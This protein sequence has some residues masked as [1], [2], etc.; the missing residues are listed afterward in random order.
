MTQPSG[1]LVSL[2]DDMLRDAGCGDDPEFRDVLLSLG[3]LASL[4][5]P[6]PSAELAALLA[7]AAGTPV[8][9]GALEDPPAGEQPADDL[10]RR[11]RRHRPTAL[12]LVLV[13]AMGLGVGGVAASSSAPGSETLQHVLA[14]WTPPW[15]APS[16]TNASAAGGG[17]RSPV[18]AADGEVPGTVSSPSPAAAAPGRSHATRL[19]E[20]AAGATGRGAVRS[21]GGASTHDD[22]G[23]PVACVPARL[24]AAFPAAPG[25]GTDGNG[26]GRDDGGVPPAAGAT[27]PGTPA[28]GKPDAPAAKAPA[29]GQDGPGAATPKSADA[30]GPV[31][32]S[33]GQGSGRKAE[34]PA[35]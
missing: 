7:P 21:C 12:G 6:A 25:G 32:Q 10:A 27:P 3:S 24:G 29:V 5:A 30:P 9:G 23:R 13:A 35:K 22:G 34:S 16:T 31:G 8:A 4:P 17:Y 14:D 28:A 11:R 26:R 20:D 15:G 33:P 19:L 2:V 18:P 1:N